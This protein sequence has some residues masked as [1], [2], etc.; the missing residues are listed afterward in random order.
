MCQH[1]CDAICIIQA[2][3]YILISHFSEVVEGVSG[4]QVKRTLSESGAMGFRVPSEDESRQAAEQ[5]ALAEATRKTVAKPPESD[6]AE[7]PPPPSDR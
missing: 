7:S 1:L 4:C 6:T 5:Y 2:V 3:K